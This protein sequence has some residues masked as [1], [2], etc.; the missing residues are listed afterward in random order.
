MTSPEHK[1]SLE[2]GLAEKIWK[3]AEDKE[4]KI[5][6]IDFYKMAC[7]K[8]DARAFLEIY[9]INSKWENSYLLTGKQHNG[10]KYLEKS[11]RL[12]YL[13][14]FLFA[15][16]DSAFNTYEKLVLIA[17]GMAIA[18]GSKDTI[19]TTL[20][21]A[22]VT[23]SKDFA[24]E[25]IPEILQRGNDLK[26]SFPDVFTHSWLGT[27]ALEWTLID[28]PNRY[29]VEEDNARLSWSIF[30]QK[31]SIQQ[32]LKL[33]AGAQDYELA[34]KAED[35]GDLD[36]WRFHLQNAAK[37]GNGQAAYA[38][39]EDNSINTLLACAENGSPDAF[40]DI[41]EKLYLENS[42]HEFKN[43]SS[44]MESVNSSTLARIDCVL[45]LYTA[46][47][48]LGIEKYVTYDIEV[49]GLSLETESGYCGK[50]ADL[51]QLKYQLCDHREIVKINDRVAKWRL[52]E[53]FDSKFSSS[54]AKIELS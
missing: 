16:N 52:G 21:D 53:K 13:P 12:Q 15:A 39:K 37:R 35:E 36:L 10:F 34:C 47:E 29:R 17:T 54:L 49:I 25:F 50:H 26:N 11:L 1:E 44:L 24:K 3:T 43:T 20:Q 6:A 22:F 5:R 2:F 7:A 32:Y 23:V 8:N 9:K 38:L 41:F 33:I 18:L 27:S 48:R 42:V 31:E 19:L 45:Y 30:P 51:F 4:S 14:A 40:D 28:H 46:M